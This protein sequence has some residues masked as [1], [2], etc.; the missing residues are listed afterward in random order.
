MSDYSHGK[1]TAQHVGRSDSSRPVLYGTLC[2]LHR[3][4]RLKTNKQP[5]VSREDP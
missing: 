1:F 5:N 4:Q 2:P 3:V